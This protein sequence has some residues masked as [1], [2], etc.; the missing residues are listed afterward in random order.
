[1]PA[2]DTATASRTPSD[3]A[4]RRRWPYAGRGQK[5]LLLASLVIM[6]ASFLPWVDTAVGTFTGMAGPGVW[7]LY[8]GFV[9]LGGA[10][11]RRRRLAL[12]QA[13]VTSGVAVA[14]PVWQLARLARICTWNSCVPSTGLLLVLASGIVAGMAAW[15]LHREVPASA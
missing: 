3:A 15:Q 1:M 13:V 11:V 12:I 7:T 2:M 6:V 5:L 4:T 8:A 10:L 9:G 14:L